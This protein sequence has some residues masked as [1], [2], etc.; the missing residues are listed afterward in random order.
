M[1]ETTY[2]SEGVL[3][4]YTPSGSDAAAGEIVFT[5]TICGQVVADV[6]DG[7]PGALRI[8]GVIKVPKASAT[9]IAGGADVHWDDSAGLAVASSADGV[10]GK[11]VGGGA[12]GDDHVLCKLNA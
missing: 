1:S 7:K 8:E 5:G 11:A 9:V 2:H 6:A 4:D 3:I 12:D 10:M